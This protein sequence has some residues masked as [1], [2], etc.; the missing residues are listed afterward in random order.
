MLRHLHQVLTR[1]PGRML[2]TTEPD[3]ENR[4]YPNAGASPIGGP[5][6]AGRL[7]PHNSASTSNGINSLSTAHGSAPLRILLPLDHIEIPTTHHVASFLQSTD[8]P[9]NAA[10]PPHVPISLRGR[11]EQLRINGQRQDPQRLE[12]LK[13]SNEPPP[14]CKPSTLATVL[15][16]PRTTADATTLEMSRHLYW[17]TLT[18]SATDFPSVVN[19]RSRLRRRR[20]PVQ[21]PTHYHQRRPQP[22]TMHPSSPSC[23]PFPTRRDLLQ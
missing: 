23:L 14:Q 7:R 1:I 20:R 19:N 10:P 12:S 16:E 13:H 2:G 15:A 6:N 9:P 4:P 3:T 21:R 8:Q 17:L 5:A 11:C 22:L 18:D